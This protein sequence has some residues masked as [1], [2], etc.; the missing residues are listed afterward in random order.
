MILIFVIYFAI[1][2]VHPDGNKFRELYI[3]PPNSP[4]NVSFGVFWIKRGRV[5]FFKPIEI[6]LDTQFGKMQ[7]EPSFFLI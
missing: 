5:I 7:F 2:P 1:M 4:V 3:C 6:E